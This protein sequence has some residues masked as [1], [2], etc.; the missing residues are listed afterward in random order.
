MTVQSSLNL[1][2]RWQ[3]DQRYRYVS[4]LPARHVDAYGALNLRLGGHLSE[5]LEWSV[6]GQNLLRAKHVEFAHDPPPPG[7]DHE[8]DRGGYCVATVIA[9]TVRNP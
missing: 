6:A 7:C 8:N 4:A 9:R 2:N 1:P 3:L 5:S